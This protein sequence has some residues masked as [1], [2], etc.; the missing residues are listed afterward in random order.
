MSDFEDVNKHLE[1]VIKDIDSST[2]H[3]TLK[4]KPYLELKARYNK[5]FQAAILE[6]KAKDPKLTQ[7]DLKARATIDTDV[8]HSELIGHESAYRSG[9]EELRGLY[10]QVEALKELSFNLRK[11]A[12]L[13]SGR[14]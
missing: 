2:F 5:E 7:T 11:E 12:G 9:K 13:T 4:I 14:T 3:L 1:K 10:L 6:H 8:T